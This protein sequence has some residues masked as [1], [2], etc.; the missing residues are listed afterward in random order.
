[1]SALPE[2]P[3]M[4]E[5]VTRPVESSQILTLMLRAAERVFL[6]FRRASETRDWTWPA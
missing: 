2:V 5:R 1:M 3:E 6:W 4:V